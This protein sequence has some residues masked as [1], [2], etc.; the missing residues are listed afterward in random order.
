VWL[1]GASLLPLIR[2]EENRIHEE[3]F[4]EVS[5]HGAY[6]PQRCVRTDRYKYIRR[7]D[8][9][10]KVLIVN[11]DDTP[12]KEVLIAND[13][14]EQPRQEEMLFDLA[15]DPDETHNLAGE[16]RLKEVED[17][18]RGRLD[19]WMVETKEPLLDGPA[20]LPKEAYANDPDQSSVRE[21]TIVRG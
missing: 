11:A 15:F 17:D 5:Y 21:D 13:W 7:Y 20:P 12:S 1:R 3:V 14:A 19:R 8:N 6:E 2:G 16:G 10:E 18:L 4:A 9:R